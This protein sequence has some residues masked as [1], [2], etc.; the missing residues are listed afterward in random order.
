MM[1]AVYVLAEIPITYLI[2]IRIA[3]VTVMG[4]Q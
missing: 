3:M 1:T 4:Q 2:V